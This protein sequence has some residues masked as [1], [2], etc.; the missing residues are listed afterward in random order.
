MSRPKVL[1]APHMRTMVEIFSDE[2]I[3]RLQ[4]FAE[5]LWAKDDPLPDAE[6][7]RLI[8]DA[9]AYVAGHPAASAEL[10][11]NAPKLK[12]VIEVAGAFPSTIDYGTCFEHGV[13]VL[14]CAP[15][16]GEQVAEMALAMML[17]GGR[18]LVAEHEAF[19][20]A[21]EEWQ[22]DRPDFDFSLYDQE[23][24]FIGAGSI[25]RALL[26]LLRPFRCRVRAYDPW[27][28][29]SALRQ[30]GCEPASLDE[31][32]Q[33]SRAVVVLAVPS[34]E[35][36]GLLAAQQFAAMPKGS[37]LVLISRSHLVDFEAMT[38]AVKSGHIQAAIDVFPEEPYDP[39]G[40][41]RQVPNTILS[42]HRAASIRK[43]R[44]AI[45]KMVV[46]DLEMMARG[47][48]PSRLLSAQPELIPLYASTE[49]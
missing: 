11:A 36:E 12:A 41:I 27:L 40:A 43:N 18:G 16:F 20:S 25:A 3:E 45:G 42:A 37:L 4:S 24:G 26:P 21:T 31:V 49:G 35:N 38:E 9:W 47:I 34:R 22:H 7:N 44:R 17:A 14:C 1:L 15:A 29:D 13:R 19:R 8:G 6:L 48:P 10:L 46:D 39:A 30:M 23:I 33:H 32:L 28:P 5:V 2:D